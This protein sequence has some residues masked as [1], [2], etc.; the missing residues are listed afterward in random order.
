[1][2][3]CAEYIRVKECSKWDELYLPDEDDITA[4]AIKFEVPNSGEARREKSL[5]INSNKNNLKEDERTESKE[6]NKISLS[7]NEFYLDQMNQ[8]EKESV[9]VN[10]KND[11]SHIGN[12]T[13]KEED[14][15]L[16]IDFNPEVINPFGR[17]FSEITKEIKELSPFRKFETY[18]VKIIP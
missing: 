5:Q 14:D 10:E 2:K 6:Q 8:K 12:F 11:N 3:L 13:V 7:I 16:I 1:V 17:K 18:S 9:N 15:S 4:K